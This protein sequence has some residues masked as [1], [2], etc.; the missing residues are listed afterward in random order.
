M[1]E[2]GPMG[3]GGEGRRHQKNRGEESAAEVPSMKLDAASS[4]VW[5]S[6]V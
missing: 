3:Q 4:R 1:R 5:L 6:L 2:E